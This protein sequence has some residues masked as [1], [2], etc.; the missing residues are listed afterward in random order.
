MVDIR[1]ARPED[2][3]Q[4]ANLVRQQAEYQ[5]RLA[6]DI[7][8]NPQADWAGYVS[9]KLQRRDTTIL[10][11][12]QMDNL[13]GYIEVRV[14]QQG[15]R[16]TGVGLRGV[17]RW[18]AH[19]FRKEPSPTIQPRR[20]GFIEDIYVEPSMRHRA[21]GVGVK[22]FNSSLRWFESQKVHEIEGAIWTNNQ[23]AQNFSRKL[24]F[25]PIKVLVRKRL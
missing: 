1:P 19:S 18:A 12:Q 7:L 22:L 11:A 4:I 6:P 14:V 15:R 25:E 16:S 8:L 24:G 20:F 2:L 3:S 23:V 10:V 9:S 21:V 5:Q 13:V 17:L